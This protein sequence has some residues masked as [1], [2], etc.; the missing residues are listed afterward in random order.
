LGDDNSI[1]EDIIMDDNTSIRAH[2][3]N[4]PIQNPRP[5]IKSRSSFLP[6]DENSMR[7]ARIINRSKIVDI[8]LL[9]LG[10]DLIYDLDVNLNRII[11]AAQF[12]RM[13]TPSKKDESIGWFKR[14]KGQQS[15]SNNSHY[16]RLLF[17]VR[18]P[19]LIKIKI[20][21]FLLSCKILLLMKIYLI[22]F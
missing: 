11:I 15:H 19:K 18:L 20:T 8:K 12:M 2:N 22:G 16:D 7:E 5:L 10:D 9:M 1:H 17:F 13:I 4:N 6:R 14:S 3:L 21:K